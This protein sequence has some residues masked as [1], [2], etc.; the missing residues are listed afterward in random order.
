MKRTH[1][2]ILVLAAPMLLAQEAEVV[3]KPGG[4]PSAMLRP[5]NPVKKELE[6]SKTLGAYRDAVLSASTPFLPVTPCRVMDTRAG[7]GKTGSFGPPTMTAG[8]VRSVPIPTSG[9][10]VPAGAVAYSL[11]ITVVPSQPLSF[12]TVYPTGS[13]RPNVSTLN[14]FDGAVVANAAVVPAGTNGS[15][16]VFVTD[17]TDVIVDINGYFQAGANTVQFYTVTPCRV[18]DTRTGEGKTGA[19]G[20]PVMTGGTSRDV[21]IPQ[22]TCGLPASAKAYLLNVTVVPRGALSFL[23]AYPTGVSRP[24]VSTLNS[25]QGRIV[26]NAALVPAGTNGAV[27]IFVTDTTDVIVDINGYLAP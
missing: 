9:C 26:A 17:R 10:G 24:T 5:V 4:R 16:D 12:L 11:N 7:E 6:P 25:F 15:I 21:P 27:T 2:F 19:F 8:T 23:S 18:M 3:K 14:S 1:C 22:S 13:A 20:P